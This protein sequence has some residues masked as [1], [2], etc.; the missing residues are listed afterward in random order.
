MQQTD[1]QREKYVR[2]LTEELRQ[3]EALGRRDTVDA[4]KAELSRLGASA[5]APAQRAAKRPA[6]KRDK[7]RSE[8]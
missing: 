1:Q 3:A 2:A 5:A 6:P 4:V 8:E 7:R